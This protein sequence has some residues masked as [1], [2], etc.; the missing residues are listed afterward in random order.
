MATTRISRFLAGASL[1]GVTSLGGCW[2]SSNSTTLT[3]AVADTPVDGAQSVV[4]TFTGVEVQGASGSPIE[5]G[6]AT[7]QAI[8]LLQLQDDD[9]AFLLDGVDIPAGHYQWI[10]M[11][12]DMSRSHITLADGS[13]HPLVLTGSDPTGL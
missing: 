6:F 7:P 11:T 10:R 5:Y 4:V 1:L 8:D 12:V 9:F 3:L 13:A 2:G